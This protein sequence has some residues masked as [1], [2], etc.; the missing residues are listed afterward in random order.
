MENQS[1]SVNIQ[2]IIKAVEELIPQYCQ[3]KDVNNISQVNAA[4]C[5]I[6]QNGIVSGKLFGN[7]KVRSREFFR[8]AWT[9]ASQV[10]ITNLKTGEYE[11]LVF[12]CEIDEHLFGISRP[13]LIGWEGGQPVTLK[14]STRLSIGFSGFSGEDDLD[15]VV[16]AIQKANL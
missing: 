7:D 3:K 5:I 9:K 12:N 8:I 16:K 15:I 1:I 14:D 4:V 2:K 6:D 10:W 11:R 13:D